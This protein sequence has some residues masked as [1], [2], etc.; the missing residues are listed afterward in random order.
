MGELND[1]DRD[2][3][4][5]AVAQVLAAG[6]DFGEMVV[7]MLR[8]REWRS[9]GIFCSFSR[10]CDSLGL[11]PWQTVP[12]DADGTGRDLAADELAARLRRAGLSVFEPSP[13]EALTLAEKPKRP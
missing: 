2:A 4:E 3:L 10:Q 9:V 6:G 1:V 7:E 13:I 11:R 12:C 8:E 5:R